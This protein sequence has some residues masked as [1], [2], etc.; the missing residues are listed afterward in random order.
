MVESVKRV[1]QEYAERRISELVYHPQNPNQGDVGAIAESIQVNGFYGAL[2]V[3]RSTGYVVAGNHRLMAAAHLKADSVPVLIADLTDEEALRIMV[4]DNRTAALAS[5]DFDD[6][7][8]ILVALADTPTGLAGTGHD[9]DDLDEI[10]LA[11]DEPE[12]GWGTTGSLTITFAPHDAE[13]VREAVTNAVA[14]I[15][16][17]AVRA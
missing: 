11:L 3:Q 9:G 5:I 10:V 6:L 17:A 12:D 16:S 15:E 14:S 4:A 13:Q 8:T 1:A 7:A 2:L